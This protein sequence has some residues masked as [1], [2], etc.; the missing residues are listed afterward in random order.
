MDKTIHWKFLESLEPARVVQAR[1]TDLIS[2]ENI[3]GQ[4]TVRFHTQQV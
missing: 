2:K 4:I 1:Y 3:F